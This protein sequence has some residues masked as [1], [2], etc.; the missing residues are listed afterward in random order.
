MLLCWESAGGGLC[1]DALLLFFD[2]FVRSFFHA[3]F[4]GA[5]WMYPSIRDEDLH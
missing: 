5:N 1:S 3:H 2:L 4:V